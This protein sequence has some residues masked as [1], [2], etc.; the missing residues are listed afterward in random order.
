MT[1]KEVF[2]QLEVLLKLTFVTRCSARK[3]LHNASAG[4]Q[5]STDDL[6][7]C[8][9]FIKSPLQH[10]QNVVSKFGVISAGQG[11]ELPHLE[12]LGSSLQSSREVQASGPLRWANIAPK[13][14]FGRS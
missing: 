12:T 7:Y 4:S 3:A 1:I 2:Y 5:I 13:L 14:T 10:A 8:C 6:L 11:R 9:A